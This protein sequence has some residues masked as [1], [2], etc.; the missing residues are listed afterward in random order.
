[1]DN[2]MLFIERNSMSDTSI[3]TLVA[4]TVS[5]GS[6]LGPSTGFSFASPMIYRRF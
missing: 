2:H 6:A 3:A 1:M 5:P 4:Y